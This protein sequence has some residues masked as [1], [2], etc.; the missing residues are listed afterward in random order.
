M[1]HC[2]HGLSSFFN[3]LVYRIG[4]HVSTPQKS[5]V[6]LPRP[7]QRLN[8]IELI[9]AHQTVTFNSTQ[10]AI[11]SRAALELLTPARDP[12][13]L[14]PNRTHHNIIHNRVITVTHSMQS[15]VW[16][17]WGAPIMNPSLSEWVLRPTGFHSTHNRHS[18]QKHHS[19]Q[20]REWPQS[21]HSTLHR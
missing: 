18:T 3:S 5:Y 17:L 1:L 6:P 19:S 10:F 14:L 4:M 13:L 21:L 2:I 9:I 20:S 7:P 15:V 16:S 11:K 8:L 12:T